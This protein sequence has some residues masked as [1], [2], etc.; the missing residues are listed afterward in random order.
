M[1]RQKTPYSS[2]RPKGVKEAAWRAIVDAWENGLSDREAA[3]R[4]NKDSD[5]RITE[6]EIKE[7]IVQDPDIGGLKDY[8]HSALTSKA[9]LNIAEQINTGN[10]AMS[11]WYLERKAPEEFSSKSAIAFEGAVVDVSMEEKRKELTNFM[12]QFTVSTNVI[13]PEIGEIDE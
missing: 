13:V 7:M 11:K 1:S 12:E 10:G 6:Q 9:K 3:Y 2:L 4:A 5:V 8:L